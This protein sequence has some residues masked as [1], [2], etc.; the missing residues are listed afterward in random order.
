MICLYSGRTMFLSVSSTS[1][2]K[3]ISY[4]VM[5]DRVG[6]CRAEEEKQSVNEIRTE[7]CEVIIFTKEVV[8]VRSCQNIKTQGHVPIIKG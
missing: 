5:S 8:V 6:C 7:V 1:R 2:E 4:M 3:F